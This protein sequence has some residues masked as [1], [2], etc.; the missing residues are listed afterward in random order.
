MAKSKF[1][2]NEEALNAIFNVSIP[3]FAKQGF[4]GVSIRQV[5]TAVGVSIATIYHHFPDK[6]ALYLSSIEASFKDIA[7]KL[8]AALQPVG[9]EEEQLRRFIFQFTELMANDENL[10]LLLQRE[11]L[12]ADEER[13]SLLANNVFMA[14]WVNV[15]KL[16]ERISPNSDPHMTSISLFS[17][18][19]Y[20]LESKPMRVFFPGGKPEHDDPEFIAEHVCHLLKNGVFQ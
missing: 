17:L 20:H 12:E 1:S 16:V 10:R 19:F 7:P 8:E 11:L 6:K 9:S 15:L 2:T 13:I 14:Q 4:S 18:V 5:A 3:L